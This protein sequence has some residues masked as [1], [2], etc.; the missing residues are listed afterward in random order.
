MYEIGAVTALAETLD[1]VDFNDL[2]AYVGVSSGGSSLPSGQR[3]H[4]RG[5]RGCSSKAKDRTTNRFIRDT[6]QAGVRE[7]FRR[8]ASFRRCCWHRSALRDHP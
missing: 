5:W 4:R 7:Y 2:Y 1:G 3:L 8:A 6:A